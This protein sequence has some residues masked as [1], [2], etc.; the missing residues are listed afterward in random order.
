MVGD[1]DDSDDD[2]DDAAVS[3]LSTPAMP[4]LPPDGEPATESFDGVDFV[5]GEETDGTDDAATGFGS[6]FGNLEALFGAMS[7]TDPDP[8]EEEELNCD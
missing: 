8:E 4:P 2:D 3:M 6:I 7:S 1:S 5:R